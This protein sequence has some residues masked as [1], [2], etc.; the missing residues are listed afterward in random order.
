MSITVEFSH[1]FAF[2]FHQECFLSRR[3]KQSEGALTMSLLTSSGWIPDTTVTIIISKDRSFPSLT[4]PRFGLFPNFPLGV[5]T[6]AG[7]HPF[8]L[9]SL[10]WPQSFLLPQVRALLS[11]STFSTQWAP[12]TC[13]G[14]NSV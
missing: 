1:L 14:L 9:S 3:L 10:L 2:Q 4:S 7:W 13:S 6:L 5:G 8:W 11:S 12:H